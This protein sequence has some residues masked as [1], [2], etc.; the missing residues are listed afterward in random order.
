MLEAVASHEVD[1]AAVSPVSAGYY[2]ARHPDHP[3]TVLRPDEAE[4]DLVWNIAV[5][6]RRPDAA[7][8]DAM[9]AALGRLWADGT[10]G[11][12]YGRYGVVVEGAR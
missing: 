2:N 4:R 11:R 6:M 8:T 1:A 12:I 3:V 5:G 10:I 7:L 9:N